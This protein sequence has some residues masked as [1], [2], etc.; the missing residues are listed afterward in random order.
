MNQPEAGSQEP[1]DKNMEVDKDDNQPLI[2]LH[3]E[4]ASGVDNNTGSS[5]DKI[6]NTNVPHYKQNEIDFSNKYKITDNGPYYV[7]VEHRDKNLGRLY[8]MRVG[9][10]LRLSNEYKKSIIDIKIMGR[11]RVKV[12][13]DNFRAANEMINN[14]LLT[15]N[16][17]LAYVPKFY[18]QK[19]GLVRMV[20]TFFSDD[21]LLRN[22]ECNRKVLEVKRLERKV[23][24][25]E[26]K[27]KLVKRQM[28]VISFQGNELPQCIR[29][30]GVNF[31]VEPYIHPVVQC[32]KCLRY[33]HISK[34]CKNDDSC[35]KKCS[36]VHNDGDCDGVTR[37]LY[38]KTDGNHSTM[39]KQCPIYLKQRRIK[40]LMAKQN[41]SFKEAEAIENNPS[42]SKVVTNNRFQIL[43]N[44]NNFPA[45]PTP[46]SSLSVPLTTTRP[47]SDRSSNFRSAST[48]ASRRKKR[49]AARSPIPG[50]PSK[51]SS[52]QVVIP[53]PFAQEFRDYKQKLADRLLHFFEDLMARCQGDNS[54]YTF[55]I[56]DS[57]NTLLAEVDNR[58]GDNNSFAGQSSSEDSDSE[59]NSS[60][61][62]KH[63]TTI[64][65]ST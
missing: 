61:S 12:I 40:E 23:V 8:P 51:N 54:L 63:S 52:T 59:I 37:C 28:V 4:G 36:R 42:Y 5:Q 7:F 62:Y 17:L 11:N 1:A 20:D 44:S 39:S 64:N 27:E 49:K 24:D 16:G 31:H 22:I 6:V 45:L 34:L 33:G 38:C 47:R 43:D 19:K 35:C 10:Y 15:K 26:G 32:H 3:T 13:L 46:S 41:L 50:S 29:I 2:N 9:Y 60:T 53:N 56:K 55:N 57:L 65:H 48:D 25:E 14:D 18:T 30:N 58:S 21:Y